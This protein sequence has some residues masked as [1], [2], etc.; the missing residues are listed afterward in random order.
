M[1]VAIS[2]YEGDRELMKRWARHVEKLGPYPNHGIIVAPTHNASTEGI[3]EHLQ[4]FAKVEVRNCWHTEKGWP[5]SCNAA[6]EF[7]GRIAESETKSPFLFMEP[8]AIPL[9]KGWIDKIQEEYVAC[10][11]PY[12]GDFVSVKHIKWHED[13]IDHMSGIAVYPP[14]LSARSPSIFRNERIPWDLASANQVIPQM[15]R[16]GL[17]HHDFATTG[18]WRRDVVDAA[19]VR[20]GAVIYHPDK[21]GVLF[22]DGLSPN[23]VQGDP[24]TGGDLVARNPHETKDI[25]ITTKT[26]PAGTPLAEEEAIQKAINI[27]LFHASIS[28]KNKK[29]I[30]EWLC[31]KGLATKAKKGAKRA[32]G[33]VRKNLGTSKQRSGVGGGTQ[34]P[35]DTE[36]A[37]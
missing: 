12:M 36:V 2:Y 29:K 5:I 27:L 7:L 17:I 35:R 25:L 37:V 33:K 24:A 1:I 15:H 10:G 13:V 26:I 30:T 20:E 18:K 32:G 9:C 3:V 21:Q 8:D 19:C 22:N 23:G 16:T 34:I 4:G 11:R 6:F 14:N 28:S 31:E